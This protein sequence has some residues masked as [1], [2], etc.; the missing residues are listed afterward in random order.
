MSIVTNYS[1]QK[2]KEIP[3][4]NTVSLV[5]ALVL[6]HCPSLS[7]VDTVH[8]H[9]APCDGSHGGGNC[10]GYA[11][12]RVAGRQA[13]DVYCNPKTLSFESMPTDY[14]DYRSDMNNL[15]N[16]DIVRILGNSHVVFVRTPNSTI[17][18]TRVDELYSGAENLDIALSDAYGGNIDYEDLSGFWRKKKIRTAFTTDPP[19]GALTVDGIAPGAD[20]SCTLDWWR[21]ITM[22]AVDYRRDFNGEN[23]A[24]HFW[25]RV[26]YN[27]IF[28]AQSIAIE[29]KYHGHYEANYEREYMITFQTSLPGGYPG[30][31]KV[32]ESTVNSPYVI[33]RRISSTSSLPEAEGVSQ[34]VSRLIFGFSSWNNGDGTNPR[35]FTITGDSTYTAIYSVTKPLPPANVSA[36]GNVGHSV[37]VTWDQ[38]PDANVTYQIWRRVKPPGEEQQDPVL[39]ANRS[40]STTSWTDTEYRVTSGYTHAML[41]YDVR[42]YYQPNATTSDPDFWAGVTAREFGAKKNGENDEIFKLQPLPNEFVV[43]NYPNPFNPSTTISYQIPEDASIQLEI[44]DMMGKRIAVLVSDNKAAGYYSVVWSG[45]NES[46][47]G[48]A[49][50][51]YLY[52]FTATPVSGQK[53]FSRSGKLLLMK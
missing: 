16:G 11:V 8:G 2:K 36:G 10:R 26:G 40:N 20:D 17:M 25:N 6:I 49:S 22:V 24:I 39:M 44:Y 31:L 46:G 13:G 23:H 43:S 28:Y 12:G 52:R 7:Q 42:S 47:S 27:D 48:V 30:T 50:G 32:N 5:L 4:R 38:H 15:T 45:K 34:E 14:F 51:M 53:A 29:P 21:P 41:N 33:Y 18:D 37:Q 1:H 35:T 9:I 3:M 19:D